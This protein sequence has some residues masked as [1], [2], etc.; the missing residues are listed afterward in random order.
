MYSNK[1]EHKYEQK[2]VLVIREYYMFNLTMI[3]NIV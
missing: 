1:H 3:V 2:H